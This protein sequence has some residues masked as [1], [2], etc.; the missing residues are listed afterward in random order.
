MR[1]ID[2]DKFFMKAYN[3]AYPVIH[4]NNDRENG[5]TMYGIAQILDEQPTIDAIPVVRCKDCTYWLNA[6]VNEKGF[7]ICP[8]SGTEITED[9]FCSYGEKVTK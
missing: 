9:D 1:L 2:A 5:L 6:E 4:G 7:V 3:T 8:A